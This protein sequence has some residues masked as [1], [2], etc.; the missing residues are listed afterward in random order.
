MERG[1]VRRVAWRGLHKD[2][3]VG[4]SQCCLLWSTNCPGSPGGF[5]SC[6]GT[7]CKSSS[8]RGCG[9]DPG[10]PVQCSATRGTTEV[11]ALAHDSEGLR[12]VLCSIATLRQLVPTINQ[13][14]RTAVSSICIKMAAHADSKDRQ[15]LAVIGDEVRTSQQPIGRHSSRPPGHRPFIR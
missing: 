10:V 2:K 3:M 4:S 5:G 12:H 14:R 13:H 11:I 1:M 8:A 15:F 6:K 9:W 7:H